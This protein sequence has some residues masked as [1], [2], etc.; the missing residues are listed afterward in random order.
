MWTLSRLKHICYCFFIFLLVLFFFI[1]PSFFRW[2][3]IFIVVSIN[4]GYFITNIVKILLFSYGVMIYKYRAYYRKDKLESNT[5]FPIYSILLP[6]RDEEEFVLSNLLRSIT[7]LDYPKEKMDIKLIVDEDDTKT[8]SHCQNLLKKYSFDLVVVPILSKVKSKPMSCNYALKY[9]KGEYLTIYDAEDRPEKYQLK[10]S[11]QRFRE[12]GEDYVCLQASLNYYNKY[13]NYLSY[14]FSIEYSM[15]FDFTLPALS[16][17]S[18]FFPLGGTSNHFRVDKLLEIGG[19]DGYNVTEDAELGLR[20]ARAGYRIGTINS[21][22]EEE[23]PISIGAWLKQRT[24]WIKGFIQTSCEHIM[25]KKPIGIN[26]IRAAKEKEHPNPQPI[27]FKPISKLNIMDIITFYIFIGMSFFFFISIFAILFNDFII[28]KR[29]NLNY[30][31]YLLIFNTF[32]IFIMLYGAFIST[33]IK[34]KLKFK[35]FYFIF[36]PLYWTLHYIAA[37]RALY[38]IVKKPFYWAKTKHG[39]SKFL[40][41][42]YKSTSISS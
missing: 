40:K 27:R 30:L 25:L 8:I 35:I 33:V 13:D 28:L 20:I 39:A 38:F 4:I 36:F 9:I 22:T 29:Y 23:C 7:N 12:L 16:K 24:R 42:K 6:V 21:I 37:V 17:V 26:A 41:N 15:W 5:D 11:L 32:S 14:C 31:K 2:F 19:W 34:N 18:N 1:L 3:S 10:K